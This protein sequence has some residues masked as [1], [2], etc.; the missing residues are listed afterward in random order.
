[1]YKRQ[2]GAWLV[3]QLAAQALEEKRVVGA[4]GDDQQHADEVQQLQALAGEMQAGGDDQHGQQ[5]WRDD[6]EHTPWRTQRHGEQADDCL[7]YTSRK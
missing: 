7:L 2:D 5:Q 6:R 4:D 1:M 3:L